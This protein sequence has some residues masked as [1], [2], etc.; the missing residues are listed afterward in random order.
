MPPRRFAEANDARVGLD[1]DDGFRGA[2]VEARRPPEWRVE[3]HVDMGDADIGYFQSILAAIGVASGPRVAP[4]SDRMPADGGGARCRSR[5][6]QLSSQT[7]CRSIS[8]VW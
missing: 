2:S 3:R 4:V 8:K 6:A 1:L 5:S 7:F